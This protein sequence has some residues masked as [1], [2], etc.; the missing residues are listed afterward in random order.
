[1]TQDLDHV[2]LTRFN[3]PSV[4]AEGVIRAQDGWLRDRVALFERYCLPSVRS[5][6]NTDFQWIIY[7]DPDSPQWLRERIDTHGTTYTAIFRESV[8]NAQLLADIRSVVGD[9]RSCL[10]T[11]NLDNDDGLAND[12]IDQIQ[13]AVTRSSRTAIYL[14]NGLITQSRLLYLR[15]DRSNAFCSVRELWD[16]ARTCW[17]DWHNLLGTSMP[18]VVVDAEPAWLQ[19]VHARNVSNRVRGK[20]VSPS[21]YRSRFVGLLDGVAAPTP[22][23]QMADLLLERPSRFVRE[24]GRAAAKGI[25][26][27]L[28]GK[29]GLGR[30]RNR[31]AA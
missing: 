30:L 20:L 8:S 25:I 31:L 6:T 7:F 5:Q 22:R 24:S 13:S 14:A 19:V 3:L 27:R 26:M 2:L 4:G 16:G 21:P 1:M 9:N 10:I 15:N 17:S 29:D 11:T 12:F 18:V 28:F 23:E